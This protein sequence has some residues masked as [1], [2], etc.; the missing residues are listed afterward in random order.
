MQEKKVAVLFTG[1]IRDAA[2]FERSVAE[3]AA[4]PCVTQIIFST[5]HKDA[6]DNSEF[7]QGLMQR[8]P[9]TVVTATD[10][11][12][13]YDQYNGFR[14]SVTLR[15]GLEAVGEASHVLRTRTDTHIDPAVVQHLAN[16]DSRI[17]DP[18]APA[19]RLFREKISTTCCSMLAPFY[20]DDI[21][22]F[23]HKEDLLKLCSMDYSE[24]RHPSSAKYAHY[25][26]YYPPFRQH[27][28]QF[29]HFV[30]NE[31]FATVV[32]EELRQLVLPK[33]M[34][35]R[36]YALMLVVYYRLVSAFFC[37]DWGGYRST[38]K[39]VAAE[40][41][42]GG[43]DFR[44]DADQMND[45]NAFFARGAVGDFDHPELRRLLGPAAESLRTVSDL[46]DAASGIDYAAFF[47]E[48][49]SYAKQAFRFD[50]R[51][52]EAKAMMRSGETVSQAFNTLCWL[53]PAD[54]ANTELMY[55][56]ALCYN[57]VGDIAR[58][59]PLL[60]RCL[61]TGAPF[62]SPAGQ[63]LAEIMQQQSA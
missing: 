55:L 3:F 25:I 40:Y 47:S 30:H 45:S 42:D 11:K 48:V 37:L 1:L 6:L 63:L 18:M 62:H 27:F 9:L 38:F 4:Q 52:A 32:S 19:L 23:G 8:Y 34:E 44:M 12:L 51:L 24:F 2:L 26:R 54:P 56:L 13:V 53:Q 33:L 58:A 5:W 41:T 22:F 60:E 59:R 31:I 21:L 10:P 20:I 46:R 14:Q 49:R 43:T 61:E 29:M 28:P 36:E 39:G 17:T 35:S 15:R 57:S 16:K 50:E 7:L